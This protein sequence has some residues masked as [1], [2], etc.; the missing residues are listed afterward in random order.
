MELIEILPPYQNQKIYCLQ[1]GCV[2]A[3]THPRLEMQ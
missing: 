2:L 3:G 1:K